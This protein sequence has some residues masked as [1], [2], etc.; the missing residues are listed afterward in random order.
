MSAYPVLEFDY[1]KVPALAD[2]IWNA[3]KAGHPKILTYCGP[4]LK[5]SNRKGAMHYEVAA[6]RYEIPHILSRDEYPFACTLE[7]GGASWIGHIPPQQNCVQ[8]GMIAG[9][10]RVNGIVPVPGA[11]SKFEVRVKNHPG[12]PV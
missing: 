4:L 3:Q 6:S 8:G 11:R 9:F 7:G 1:K 5:K 12:G 10:I 2:N